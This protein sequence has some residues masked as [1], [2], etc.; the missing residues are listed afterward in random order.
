MKRYTKSLTQQKKLFEE[1][2]SYLV[3]RLVLLHER[4]SKVKSLTY[5][6]ELYEQMRELRK[7]LACIE[8]PLLR[9]HPQLHDLFNLL[10]EK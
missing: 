4:S 2:A 6:A 9:Q 8:E 3:K 5:K 1:H 7:D 10:E